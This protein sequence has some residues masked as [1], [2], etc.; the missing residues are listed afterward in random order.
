VLEKLESYADRF[1]ADVV[2]AAL[3]RRLAAEGRGFGDL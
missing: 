1:G 3:I 2:P